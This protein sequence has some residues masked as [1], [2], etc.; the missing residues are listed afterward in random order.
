VLWPPGHPAVTSG[1]HSEEDIEKVL[2]TA[3]TV[4]SG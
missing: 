4:L 3:G 1:A 2:A